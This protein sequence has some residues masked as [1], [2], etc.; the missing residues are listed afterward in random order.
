MS[1]FYNQAVRSPMP[2]FHSQDTH[3]HGPA[4]PTST[5][6]TPNKISSTNVV[7]SPSPIH[8]SSILSPTNRVNA[9][10]NSNNLKPQNVVSVSSGD[11]APQVPSVATLQ[12]DLTDYYL[13]VNPQRIEKIPDILRQYEGFEE[14]VFV[15]LEKTYGIS[16]VQARTIGMKTHGVRHE[17]YGALSSQVANMI[18]GNNDTFTSAFSPNRRPVAS[19]QQGVQQSSPPV[20]SYVHSHPG[21]LNFDRGEAICSRCGKEHINPAERYRHERLCCVQHVLLKDH[22]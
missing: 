10:N 12:R 9:V 17:S 4:T 19:L 11:P 8:S 16:L 6:F 1:S 14:Q 2:T 21:K 7:E 22:P 20:Q 5:S 15:D 18:R 13:V 3:L